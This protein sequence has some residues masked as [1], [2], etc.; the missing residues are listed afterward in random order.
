MYTRH[1]GLAYNYLNP[2][3]SCIFQ[4][5][6]EYTFRQYGVLKYH[7]AIMTPYRRLSVY[8][9]NSSLFR[10]LL[11]IVYQITQSYIFY[12]RSRLG[13][14]SSLRCSN[15]GSKG[16]P[17]VCPDPNISDYIG[18]YIKHTASQPFGYFPMCYCNRLFLWENIKS[19][20]K[21]AHLQIFFHL[22]LYRRLF[23]YQNL[24]P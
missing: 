12:E 24:L 20:L 11:R 19:F 23:V 10:T 6:A 3:V 4:C 2:C 16:L 18:P 7:V 1:I 5:R 8:S 22:Q 14:I 21:Q 13:I 17:A 9:L 15:V